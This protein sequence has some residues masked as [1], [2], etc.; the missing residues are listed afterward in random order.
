MSELKKAFYT[1]YCDK[2]KVETA[3]TF[4]VAADAAAELLNQFCIDCV[5]SMEQLPDVSNNPM[6]KDGVLRKVRI[7]FELL[8]DDNAPAHEH[9]KGE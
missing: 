1:Q 8:E 2:Q 7:T 5:A 9:L 6:Y 4:G 3:V